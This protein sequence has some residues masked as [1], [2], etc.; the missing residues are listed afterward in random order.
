MNHTTDLRLIFLGDSF[1]N[2][3]GDET[4]LGWVGRVAQSVSR[5][6]K[7]FTCYN[8][9][10]RRNTSEEI[11]LRLESELKAR[12]LPGP[13]FRLI[14][15]FGVNDCVLERGVPRVEPSRSLQNLETSIVQSRKL[16]DHILF[17]GPPPIDD[18]RI[19]LQIR[20]LNLSFQDVCQRL[21]VPC[22]DLFSNLSCDEQWFLEVRQNDG[23][24]PGSRGYK[25]IAE[26]V[27]SHP[28]W[29][30]SEKSKQ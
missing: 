5:S 4:M 19:N 18:A 10:I 12:I 27:E 8:L 28:A 30:F 25:K 7:E 29:W 22:I 1:V 9:G 26:L 14:L 15:S 23:A 20:D 6:R 16:V 2:G 11:L 13:H 21:D 17:V 3:T 24:H